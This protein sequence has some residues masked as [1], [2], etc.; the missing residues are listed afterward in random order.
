MESTAKRRAARPTHKPRPARKW[1]TPPACQTQVASTRV[2]TRVDSVSSHQCRSDEC[3]DYPAARTVWRSGPV[4]AVSDGAPRR[5]G[6]ASQPLRCV[7]CAVR[8]EDR[9]AGQCPRSLTTVSTDVGLCQPASRR[10]SL[11]E[12]RRRASST[13][14]SAAGSHPA[15]RTTGR[16]TLFLAPMPRSACGRAGRILGEACARHFEFRGRTTELNGGRGSRAPT[17]VALGMLAYRAARPLRSLAGSSA[18][19]QRGCRESRAGSAPP[20]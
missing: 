16:L 2:R 10:L 6:V 11:C 7:T 9:P 12:V 19:F 13:R 5:P 18:L 17:S 8:A 14:I 4:E 15:Q 3:R 20:A 1:S